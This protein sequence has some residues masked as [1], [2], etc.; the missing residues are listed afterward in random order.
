MIP[1]ATLPSGGQM[2]QGRPG[3]EATL[4]CFSP[5]PKCISLN[6]ITLA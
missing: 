1:A 6:A 3:K 4:Y 5:T 2:E